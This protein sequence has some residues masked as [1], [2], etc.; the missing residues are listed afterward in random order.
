VTTPGP[1]PVSPRPPAALAAF[2][3]GIE[4]RGWVFALRQAG[5][6]AAAEQGLAQALHAFLAEARGLPLA[7]WPIRFWACL[8][9]QPGLVGPA[10]P[11]AVG[12]AGLPP[13]PR[14][15]LLLRLVA[16][17]S[18]GDA[19]GV[20]GVARPTYRL[21]L[22]RALPHHEDGRPDAIAWRMLGEAA[23]HAVRELSPERLA[24]LARLREAALLGRRLDPLPEPEADAKPASS[25]SIS[26]VTATRP[27]WTKPAM[28]AVAIVCVV[29]LAATFFL[30][31]DI[32]SGNPNAPRVRIAALPP[33][34]AP[35]AKFDAQGALLLHPD[36]EQI[37][38]D[39]DAS[40]ATGDAALE[41]AAR[42][43]PAFY[44]W[45]AAGAPEPRIAP[46]VPEDSEPAKPST[47]PPTPPP[48]NAQ[49]PHTETED[50]LL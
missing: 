1:A 25:A 19:A 22:Q 31:E 7:A 30:P 49:D 38:E 27:R 3:R 48:G 46:V 42:T 34:E 4:L 44:A 39:G 36:F 15:A 26:E 17:L 6:E 13:G 16:G 23:Q 33:A 47:P 24:H 45:L 9:R 37:L 41:H 32:W 40:A 14:A 5:S 11:G 50:A 21:A 28:A 10:E 43:D 35:A 20:L 8:L 2:L 12:L 29:A 18:K